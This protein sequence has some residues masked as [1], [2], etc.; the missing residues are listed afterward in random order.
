MT[1]SIDS[2]LTA[3]QSVAAPDPALVQRLWAAWGERVAAGV[4]LLQDHAGVIVDVR[5]ADTVLGHEAASLIGRPAALLFPP[6]DSAAGA[7][8]GERE[9][10][11][12][13]GCV[14]ADR[15]LVRED[16][17][18][19]WTLGGVHAIRQG[20]RCIGHLRWFHERD[21]LRSELDAV[22]QRAAQLAADRA[23]LS[24]ALDAAIHDLANPLAPLTT[25]VRMLESAPPERVVDLLAVIDRQVGQMKRLLDGLR[26]MQQA[27]HRPERLRV[28]SVPVLPLLERVRQ[29]ALPAAQARAQVIKVRAWSSPAHLDL[30][31]D[32][33][34]LQ[35]L[36]APLLDNALTFST[37]GAT[38]WLVASADERELVVRVCDR[39]LGMEGE[40]R[41]Q[42]LSWLAAPGDEVPAPTCLGQGLPV[43]RHWARLHGGQVQVRSEGPGHGCE[44]VVRLPRRRRPPGE[45]SV[46]A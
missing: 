8:L 19:A 12:S 2:S 37:A 29:A 31:A 13:L 7:E 4:E 45:T 39:G 5:G 22:Q 24:G 21:D 27:S 28:E 18:R 10:A 42:L 1:A 46:G 38:V 15:W 17:T 6:E 11:M 40:T 30:E 41:S 32:P 14:V 36:L 20:G 43:A 3:A 16:G 26:D 9:L 34:G 25:A 44:F 35:Q 33:D 23:R